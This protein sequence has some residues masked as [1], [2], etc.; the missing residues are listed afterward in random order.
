MTL[1]NLAGVAPKGLVESI[2]TGKYSASYI[3]WSR[4]MN[5]LHEHA[6][7]WMVDYV[8]NA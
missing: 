6:P 4:T 3:N 5:L 1:P 7:G 2:G 8:P